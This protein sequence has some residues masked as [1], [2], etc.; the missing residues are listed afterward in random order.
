MNASGLNRRVTLLQPVQVKQPSGERTASWAEVATTWAEKL[1]LL[2]RD[3]A[4]AQGTAEGSEAKFRIRYRTDINT[5]MRVVCDGRT[6]AITGLEEIGHRE[7]WFVLV[8]EVSA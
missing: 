4:R 3:V 5:T 7:G 1:H 8:R 2:N 6:F